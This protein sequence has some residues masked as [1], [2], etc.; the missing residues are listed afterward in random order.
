MSE[1]TNHIEGITGVSTA[2]TDFIESAQRFVVSKIPKNLLKWAASETVSGTHGGDDSPT[3]ITLPVGTDS[4]IAVRRDSYNAKEAGLEDRAWLESSSGSLK[5]PTASFPKYYITAGNQVRVKPDP[6]SSLTAHVTY[7]DY[8]KI[9]E[10]SDLRNAVIYHASSSEFEKLASSKVT[11]WS[12]IVEPVSPALSSNSVSF[13]QSVPSYVK[14]TISLTTFPTISWNLPSRPVSSIINAESSST[15]GAEVDTNKLVSAPT[16]IPPVMQSPDWSDVENWITTEEDSEM[17]ASRI[18]AIQSQVGEYQA[19]LGQSQSDFN[20]E[21]VEYQANLQIALQDASQANSGDGALLQKFSNEVS[22]YQAEVNSILSSNQ[23]QISE[24]QQENAVKIQ[25]YGSD[26]QNE[27]NAFNKDNTEYQAQ[28]QISIQD[29]QLSSQDDAQLLQDFSAK[30]QSYSSEVNQ[31][32][33]KISS[34]LQNTNHY[35]NE[36]KKYYEWALNEVTMYIQNNSKMISSTIA[37]QTAQQ[38]RG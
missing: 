30:V 37:A 27:L 17:L 35:A 13:S 29:A 8:S 1:I 9:D 16:Y 14:P 12:D 5:I 26:M 33:T 18:Q 38:Q 3:A 28:L 23:N 22:V 19:R 34:A 6:T 20:K 25:Q 24:W 36:S 32:A 2:N 11:D 15:G 10:D 21:N 7:V 4:I 31:T